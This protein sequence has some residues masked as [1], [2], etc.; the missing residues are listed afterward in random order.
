MHSSVTL[1]FPSFA[2]KKAC[3]ERPNTQLCQISE[4][5]KNKNL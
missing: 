4:I 3:S 2:E 1:N 5:K